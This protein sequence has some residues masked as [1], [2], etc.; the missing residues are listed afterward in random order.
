MFVGDKLAISISNDE[1][2]LFSRLCR[3]CPDVWQAYCEHEF[4]EKIGDGTLAIESFRHYLLQDY[5]FLIQFARA[6]ALAVYKSSDLDEMRVSSQA[7][8]N[9]LRNE[10]HLHLNFC[11]TWGITA[12][13]LAQLSEARA[14]MAYTRYVLDQ[15][16]AE[17]L[18]TPSRLE[19]LTKTFR[20]VTLLEIDFWDMGLHVKF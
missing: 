9:I 20:E 5:L 4:V 6:H 7:L 18:E 12:A 10:I 13:D 17:Q 8:D 16:L 1:N 2:S 3:T 14:N 11:K 19:K 15:G